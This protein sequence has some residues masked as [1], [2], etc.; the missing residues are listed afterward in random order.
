MVYIFSV[1]IIVYIIVIIATAPE[2]ERQRKLNEKVEKETLKSAL[3]KHDI[4]NSLMQRQPDNN[5]Y[6]IDK[7]NKELTYLNYN[8][9]FSPT[10]YWLEDIIEVSLVID[11]ETITSTT[12]G[13]QF[14]GALVGGLLAGSA[15][16][17]VGG[18]SGSTSSKEAVSKIT[19]K[20][21]IKETVTSV[22][23][24]TFL[25][26]KKPI[27]KTEETFKTALKKANEWEGQF[28]V[29]IH[30]TKNSEDNNTKDKIK[31]TDNQSTLSIA[32]EIKKLHDLVKEGILTDEEFALQKEKILSK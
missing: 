1:L 4:H 24:I 3:I 16:A 31:S 2:R 19:L 30:E 14:G 11:G 7:E 12:R 8:N 22:K 18:L 17:I 32:D 26:V 15:G 28:K 21:T 13:S 27:L 25:D 5:V 6:I 20:L 29:I 10:Y 23:T 9:N